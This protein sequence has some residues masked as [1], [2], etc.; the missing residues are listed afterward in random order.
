ML[1][2]FVAALVH[3]S[4]ALAFCRSAACIPAGVG[5]VCSP[6]EPMRE[7]PDCIVPLAW[8]ARC[9]GYS[10]QRDGSSAVSVELA[11]E[12][13]S[14]AFDAWSGADCDGARPSIAVERQRD[15]ICAVPEYNLKGGNANVIMFRDDG[16]PYPFADETLGLATLTFDQETGQLFDVDIEINTT[17]F[18]FT[19]GDDDVGF[20]LMSTI[21]HEV[22]HFFGVAHSQFHDS[23]MVPTPNEGSTA[24]RVLAED[25]IAAI[26][27]VYPPDGASQETSC[28]PVPH[29]F[30]PQCASDR[31]GASDAEAEAG[32]GCSFAPRRAARGRPLELATVLAV[33]VALARRRS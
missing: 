21:Q 11:A 5:D 14:R 6:I 9:I 22:G 19:T 31:R 24:G 25:D 18:T 27:S 33:L 23:V 26:C 3:P 7:S 13:V 15:A 12:L 32:G 28:K 16:W 8:N 30:S 4:V 17:D 2:A 29:D 1:A 10:M 20:D